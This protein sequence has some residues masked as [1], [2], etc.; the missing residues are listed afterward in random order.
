VGAKDLIAT[1]KNF[2]YI[3][4]CY[5]INSKKSFDDLSD[6][7]SAIEHNRKGLQ[8]PIALVATKTDMDD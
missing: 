3:L 6:W 5:A 2:S 4:L 8:T 7:L 1:Q